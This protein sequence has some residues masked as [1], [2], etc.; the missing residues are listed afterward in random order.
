MPSDFDN[1]HA[2]EWLVQTTRFWGGRKIKLSCTLWPK[3][4]EDVLGCICTKK[5]SHPK[6]SEENGTINH[7][8]KI[9]LKSGPTLEFEFHYLKTDN[10]GALHLVRSDADIKLELI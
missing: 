6:N 4:V 1:E 3:A 9:W 5:P 2:G 7:V 10:D 8:A